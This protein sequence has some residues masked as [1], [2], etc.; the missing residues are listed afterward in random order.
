MSNTSSLPLTY[1]DLVCDD[2][3]D[4]NAAETTSDL[5]TLEQDIYHILLED[6]GSNPD[7]P[8]RGVG[9]PSLLSGD[10]S[11]LATIP[12]QIESQLLNDERIEQVQAQIVHIPAGGTFSDGTPVGD[13]DGYEIQIQYQPTGAV[14]PQSVSFGYSSAGG[15]LSLS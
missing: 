7:D 15:L 13:Q 11:V 8:D 10:T 2:D 6:P 3:V 14:L 5:Q 4:P 9:V 12:R 1:T